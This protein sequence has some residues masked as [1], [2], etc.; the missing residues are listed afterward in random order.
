MVRHSMVALT[1]LLVLGLGIRAADKEVKCTL[2]KV[3][4][5]NKVITVKTEDGKEHHFDVDDAT[6][7]LGVRGGLSDQGIRDDRLTKG[8]ELTLVIAGNNRTIHEVHLPQRKSGQD[9]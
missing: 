2:V 1:V 3:D 7:F 9:K 6:K 4:V 8:A 5:K